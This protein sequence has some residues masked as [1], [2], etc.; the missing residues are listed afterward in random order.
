MFFLNLTA[1]EFLTLLGA[2]GGLITALYLLDRAKRR[3]VVS[4]LQFWVHAGAAEQRQ[5]RR[6]MNQPWSLVLQLLSLLLLLLALSRVQW[7]ARE[8]RGRDHVLLLDTT[9]WTAARSSADGTGNSS[10]LESEKQQARRYLAALQPNDRI[11]LVGVDGLASP[12]TR[13]TGDHLEFNRTLAAIRP[14]FSAL[15]LSTALSFARQAQKSSGGDPGEIVYVGPQLLDENVP[16]ADTPNLRVLPVGADRE[17][18]GIRQFTAQQVEDQPNTWQ[19]FVRIRNY[20]ARPEVLRL[21]VGYGGTA[22]APRRL[23]IKPGDEITAQYTFTTRAAGELVAAIN[24]GGSLTSDDTAALSL[25]QSQIL[26]VAVYTDRPQL[27]EPL[28]KADPQLNASFLTPAQY[29]PRQGTDIVVLDRF[30][31]AIPPVVPTLWIDPEKTRSPLPVKSSVSDALMT[32][33]AGSRL[34][35]ALHAKQLHLPAAHT[36][37]LFEGDDSIAAVPEGPVVVVRAANRQHARTAIVGFDP[38]EGELRFELATPLLFADLLQWL[39]PVAFRTL[40][41]TAEQVGLASLHLDPAEQTGRLQVTDSAGFPIPFSRRRDTLQLF[42]SRPTTVHI[43]SEERE[44]VVALRLPAV[45]SRMWKA[46]AGAATGLPAAAR[47]TPP[48]ADLWK[49]LAL[50]GGLGLVVEWLL[51]GRRRR[52]RRLGQHAAPPQQPAVRDRRSE[53]VTK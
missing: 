53:L 38:A 48:A 46:P 27:L 19:A 23:S 17:N 10:V 9:S 25:P 43:S 18:C 33:S 1:A 40:T 26:R 12:L 42:V 3:K 29:S 2:F 6:K 50:A 11:M 52:P 22:F 47:V 8:R 15:N 4:S 32:W 49:W 20:G 30:A 21:D 14:G 45:A 16:L 44:R 31:P 7:G 5:A 39:D 34:N 35:L 28:L 13:F 37:E 24:P 36:F 51:F 41:L